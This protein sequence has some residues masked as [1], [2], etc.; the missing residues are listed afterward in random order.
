M[1]GLDERCIKPWDCEHVRHVP[2]K[3]H[4]LYKEY[5]NVLI[6]PTI[7]VLKY[8]NLL[9]I[10]KWAYAIYG[11]L[12]LCEQWN[13]FPFSTKNKRYRIRKKWYNTAFFRTYGLL[14]YITNI[15]RCANNNTHSHTSIFQISKVHNVSNEIS[16]SHWFTFWFLQD[17]YE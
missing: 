13:C 12:N 6:F 4:I 8:Q 16:P 2:I 11:G 1:S 7:L 17:Y 3:T 9:A 10:I 15:K 14:L 5:S